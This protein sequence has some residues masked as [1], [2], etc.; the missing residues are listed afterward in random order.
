[1]PIQILMPALSPTMTEGNLVRWLKKEGD[2]VASGDVIA[3]IETDKATMEVEAV[4]GGT[5]ARILVAEGT[6]EVK[7]NTL[8]ALLLEED[9]DASALEGIAAPT[10]PAAATP[11]TPGKVVSD[12]PAPS[13]TSAPHTA[14]PEGARVLASPLARRIADQ[15]GIA[16][17]SLAGSGPKGR[18]IKADV[19][20]ALSGQGGSQAPVAA[21]VLQGE[22]TLFPAYE[23]VKL[24]NM[25][26]VIAKRLTEAKQQVPHFYLSADIQMDALL[27]MR[28]QVN[29]SLPDT[30][31][32]SVND[33]VI[34]AIASALMTVPE[35]NASFVDGA[36]R[37]YKRADVSVAVAIE[38][39]LVTPI[40]KGANEKSLGTISKEMKTLVVKAKEGKLRPEEFQG[41]TFSLSNLGMFGIKN[42][43]AVINP[44]QGGI[45]AVGACDKRPVVKDDTLTIA[46]VMSCT[47]SVDHRVIDG[48]VAALF[49]NA[50]KK[51]L[52]N[53]L[54]LLI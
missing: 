50:L 22:D 20:A 10:T 5:L 38:G 33:F 30:A 7:V 45:L 34:K 46:S 35:A 37:L 43:S 26:K 27:A 24:T 48:A 23:E 3:E 32:I 29:A 15:G 9:E 40:I 52:E 8:I 13:D 16:L 6:E 19:E 2:L 28:T 12:A 44:P 14:P 36:M 31:R 54:T 53:P 47:L 39:G 18:I 4:D 25:R 42:F 41:G 1:M 11:A 17:D 21:P 49:L 51:A